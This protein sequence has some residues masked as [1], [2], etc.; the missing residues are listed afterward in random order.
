MSGEKPV[1]VGIVGC[2][3]IEQLHHI[4][5]FRRIREAEIVAICDEDE[6]LLNRVS[7]EKKPTYQRLQLS[8]III[9]WDEW[10][11]HWVFAFELSLSSDEFVVVCKAV[12]GTAGSAQGV[13]C[14]NALLPQRLSNALC[15]LDMPLI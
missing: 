10:K 8:V 3:S 7:G 4:P 11:P 5:F 2:G 12:D 1:R 13:E 14:R 15:V 6:A 9:F